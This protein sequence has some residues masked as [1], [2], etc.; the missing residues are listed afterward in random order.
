MRFHVTSR[1]PDM[2]FGRV[3]VWRAQ[4]R[5]QVSDP[6][7]TIIDV[8]DDP[9]LGGGVRHGADV[10]H[11]YLTREYR[12][13]TLLVEYGDRVGNRSVFK[14]LGFLLETRERHA[15]TLIAACRCGVG[16]CESTQT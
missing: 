7:R 4:T 3:G 10:L 8:L 13:D 15:D 12:N 6:S 11:E 2:I 16:V 1:A 9:R 14:R 5:V